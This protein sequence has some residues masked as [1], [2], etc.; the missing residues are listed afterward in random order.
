MIAQQAYIL[1][2]GYYGENS[3]SKINKASLKIIF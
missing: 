1:Q 2:L 3:L